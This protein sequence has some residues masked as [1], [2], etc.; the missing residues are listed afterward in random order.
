MCELGQALNQGCACHP[1]TVGT[2]EIVTT[3]EALSEALQDA[4]SYMD[5]DLYKSLDNPEDGE[6]GMTF[7]EVVD[8]IVN[9]LEKR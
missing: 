8:R 6:D 4:V 1:I 7:D 2:R 9:H 3:R 5:Y